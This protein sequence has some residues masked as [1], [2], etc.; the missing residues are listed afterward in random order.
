MAT[1]EGQTLHSLSYNAKKLV[2]IG[3]Y[4]FEKTIGE[5]NFAVV[6]RATHTVTQSK[7]RKYFKVI[8]W[9]P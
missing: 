9:H 6:K 2:R 5:G 4:E 1:M 8:L 3:H 7:V